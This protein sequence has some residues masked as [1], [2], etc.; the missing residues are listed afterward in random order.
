MKKML[1]ELKKLDVDYEVPK[2]FRKNVMKQIKTENV[3]QTHTKK[4][5]HL[6]KYVIACAS[7]AAMF[8]VVVNIGK[9]SKFMM[10]EEHVSMD[11]ASTA[12][13]E[14][15]YFVEREASTNLKDSTSLV[16]LDDSYNNAENAVSF[17]SKTESIQ[18]KII[19]KLKELNVNYEIIDGNIY[20]SNEVLQGIKEELENLSENIEII[21]NTEKTKIIIK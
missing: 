4:I 12:Q 15:S 20:V 16:K 18:E 6:K 17:A 5:R 14:N 11:M 7:V 10:L 2:D 13:D 21:E 19:I 9:E 3:N 8:I 1:D